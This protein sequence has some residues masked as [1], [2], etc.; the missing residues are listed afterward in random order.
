[1]GLMAA[2]GSGRESAG[3]KE[4]LVFALG[5]WIDVSSM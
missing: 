5:E 4:K 1:M 2:A 3:K